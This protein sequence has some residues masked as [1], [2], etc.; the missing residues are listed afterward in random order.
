LATG[1]AGAAERYEDEPVYQLCLDRL[2]TVTD[3]HSDIARRVEQASKSGF[4]GSN[5]R[6]RTPAKAI[7]DAL[8]LG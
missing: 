1:K 3:K 2:G 8:L 6:G 5:L 4:R 7:S